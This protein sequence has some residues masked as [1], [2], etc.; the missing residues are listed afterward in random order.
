MTMTGR[1]VKRIFMHVDTK[2]RENGISGQSIFQ[3]ITISRP[4]NSLTQSLYLKYT[5]KG[6]N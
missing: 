3:A 5:S 1:S 2:A 4:Y 6:K